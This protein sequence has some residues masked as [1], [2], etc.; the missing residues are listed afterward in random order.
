ML[1]RIV[2]PPFGAPGAPRQVEANDFLNFFE[3][4]DEIIPRLLHEKFVQRLIL[5]LVVPGHADQPF[6]CFPARTWAISAVRAP[7]APFAVFTWVSVWESSHLSAYP[8]AVCA[9]R[10]RPSSQG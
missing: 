1:R 4:Q 2:V 3:G 10:T 7:S 9:S 8:M 5:V 6:I